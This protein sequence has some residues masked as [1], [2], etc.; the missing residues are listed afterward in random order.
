[1][2]LTTI[3]F[4]LVAA[5]LALA[6]CASAPKETT[7]VVPPKYTDNVP[8]PKVQPTDLKKIQ[9]KI[10]NR[11]DMQKFVDANKSN[12]NVVVFV[13]DEENSAIL[14]GN[15]QEL[16]RYIE[17]QQEVIEYLKKVLDA[18]TEKGDK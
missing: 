5:M 9:W 13:L 18:R 14:I 12:P 8:I 7:I 10:M 17:S 2:K 3:K 4:A 16:R 1:M 15:I 6:G 11:A